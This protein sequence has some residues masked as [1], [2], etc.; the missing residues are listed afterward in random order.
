MTTTEPINIDG[1][2]HYEFGD[3]AYPS[4]TEIT[5]LLPSKKEALESWKKRTDNWRRKRDRAGIVGSLA[6]YRI[7]NQYAIRE[8]DPPDVDL[9]LV[10]EDVMVDVET[11][12]ALWNRLDLDVGD[13]AYVEQTTVSHEHEYAG[14]FDLYTGG[15]IY[16]LKTSKAAF[17]SYKLQVAAYVKAAR[18]MPDLPDPD[19]AAIV[20]IHYGL[21]ANPNMAAKVTTLREDEIE[22]HFERFV[23]LRGKLG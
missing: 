4:V 14:T 22:H 2:R 9:S 23:E 21:E 11:A 17:E 19:R 6:H 7:L 3:N 8:L 13:D 18:A 12:V 15:T 16:D 20:V 5:D 10:D 1:V